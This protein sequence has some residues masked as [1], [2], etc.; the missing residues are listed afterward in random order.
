[1]TD[2]PE[3]DIQALRRLCAA[4]IARAVSDASRGSPRA[5]AWLASKKATVW[6]DL[7]DIDQDV[8]LSRSQWRVWARKALGR[9]PHDHKHARVLRRGLVYL[10]S[11]EE[12]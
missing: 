4:V 3:S 12:E 11:L 1:M 10:D 9:L 5:A 7:L 8:F 2:R 6:F